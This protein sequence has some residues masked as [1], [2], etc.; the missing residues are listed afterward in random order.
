MY[1]PSR[2]MKPF[3]IAWA[4]Y[5]LVM[6]LVPV[7]FLARFH[8]PEKADFHCLYTAAVLLHTEPSHLYDLARQRSIQFDLFG[9]ENGWLPFIQP[10]DEALLIVPFSLLPYRTA[11]LLYLAFNV[12]LIVPCFLLARDAF[13]HVV[14]PWQPR[15]GLLFFF[16]LPLSLAVLQGQD[17]VRLLLFCCAAWYELKRGKNFSAGLL[18]ALALFKMQV[19]IPLALLLI[20]WRGCRALAGFAAGVVIVAAVNLWLVGMRGIHAWG[21]LLLMH[22]LIVDEAPSA[23]LATGQLP[24]SMPN[25]RG[26]LYGC[27]G[28]YLPHLWLV[29]I[30]LALSGALL[31]WVAYLL[32]RERDEATAFALA[33][34]GALLLSYHLHSHDLTLLLLPIA[35]LAGRARPYF[36]ALVSACFLLPVLVLIRFGQAHYPMAIPLLG[37]VLLIAWGP[38]VEVSTASQLE[39]AMQ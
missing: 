28:R 25:L 23:Q 6:E 9:R 11:Y 17:S 32:R 19:I 3:L 13:S 26:L 1:S 36:T 12:A 16:F 30:T 22:T 2:S 39:P 4:T 29:C 37:F 10:P 7:L 24:E 15:P 34:V 21:K 20:I 35:L 33:L 18:L 14:D 27:G 8:V 38:R 5:L 31:L